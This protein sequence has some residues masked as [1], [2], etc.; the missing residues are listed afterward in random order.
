SGF[1]RCRRHSHWLLSA[2]GRPG[3]APH[4]LGTPSVLLLPPWDSQ[5]EH[6]SRGEGP[7]EASTLGGPRG[8]AGGHLQR[9]NQAEA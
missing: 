4:R 3:R 8:Q 2:A 1:S 9:G 5:A 7:C 6:P